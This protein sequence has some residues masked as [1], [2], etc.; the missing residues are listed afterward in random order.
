MAELTQVQ[1]N[2]PIE[3]ENISLEEQSRMQDEKMQSK[4]EPNEQTTEDTYEEDRPEWLDSKFSTPE[5]L[6]KAY[7]E[8]ESKLGKQSKEDSKEETTTTVEINSVID[9]ASKQFNES[10]ELTE[11]NFK[12]LADAGIP[13]EYVEA[14]MAGIQNQIQ[15]QSSEIKSII[16]GD[17]SYSAMTEWAMD[18]LSQD[19]I[20]AFNSIVE[21]GTVSQAKVAVR[22]LYARF[23]SESGDSP[24]LLQGST[25]GS[26]TSP[27]TS[28]AQVMQ[29]M[30]DP[31]YSSDPAYRKEVER[32]MAI[33]ENPFG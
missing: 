25:K 4:G 22:G 2:T 16:G 5:E 11:E 21:S 28:A 14:Y 15:T 17:E 10:G 13:R 33:S 18:N 23:S 3:N 32:R 19:E 24:K 1:I 26:G 29:A 8:L 12:A 9:S 30:R 7:K 20:D 6:A 27:F 31:R